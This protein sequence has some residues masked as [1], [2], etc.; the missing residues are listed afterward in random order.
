[1]VAYERSQFVTLMKDFTNSIQEWTV[2]HQNELVGLERDLQEKAG[3]V[4]NPS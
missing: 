4:E 1:M 2:L 3:T